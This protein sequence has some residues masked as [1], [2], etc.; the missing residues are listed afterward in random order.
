[1]VTIS[2]DTGG[3]FGALWLIVSQPSFHLHN[4][5]TE[6][7]RLYSCINATVHHKDGSTVYHIVVN[8]KNNKNGRVLR[9]VAF[10]CEQGTRP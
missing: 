8:T 10:L 7:H 6:M 4:T 9:G 5:L 1:M 3:H 2:H